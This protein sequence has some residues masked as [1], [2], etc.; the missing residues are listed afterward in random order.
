MNKFNHYKQNTILTRFVEYL[1]PTL[2][3]G[4]RA[5]IRGLQIL[6]ASALEVAGKTF[7]NA[8]LV[9]D[10]RIDGLVWGYEVLTQIINIG[11]FSLPVQFRVND[12]DKEKILQMFEDGREKFGIDRV[13]FDAGFKGMAFFKELHDRDFLF[14]TKGTMNW[15]WDFHCFDR[16]TN[17]LLELAQFK[18][19]RN[20]QY[21]DMIVEK[22]IDEGPH[23][24]EIMKFRM[25]FV[26]GDK[27]V[28][29]TNDF[30][31][32]TKEI[33]GYY[34][35]RWKIEEMFKE[36][37]ENLGFEKLTVRETNA[38][39]THIMTAFL[40]FIF[41]HLMLRRFP[42]IKGIKLFV[43]HVIKNAAELIITIQKV[44]VK[45][46][47]FFWYRFALEKLI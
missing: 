36:E 38:I 3:I 6:D 8:E 47:K 40:A 23:K 13:S 20:Y 25:V 21:V 2:N 32:S 9:Y 31:S 43:R 4:K 28:F 39:R 46:V 14:Y 16:Q 1:F 5:K 27:R 19:R 10:S 35:R 37:K 44:I 30:E 34:C 11:G 17:E 18:F 26:K 12:L 15:H 45:F 42:S 22:E 33:Y 41:C 29:L 24:G 7:E